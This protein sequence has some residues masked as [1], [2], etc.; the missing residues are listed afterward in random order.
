MNVTHVM[1]ANGVCLLWRVFAWMCFIY[2]LIAGQKCPVVAGRAET[3]NGS[4]GKEESTGKKMEGRLAGI[5]WR[6]KALKIRWRHLSPG[7]KVASVFV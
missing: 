2:T 7:P 4:A 5:K 6:K 3:V 1:C